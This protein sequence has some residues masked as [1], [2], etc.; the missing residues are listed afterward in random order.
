MTGNERRVLDCCLLKKY[1]LVHSK[2][3]RPANN[4][5][6]YALMCNLVYSKYLQRD[7]RSTR[8]LTSDDK[9][10]NGSTIGLMY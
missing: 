5:N 9:L 10:K 8:H 1:L 2:H 3:W 4:N 7:T 6:K